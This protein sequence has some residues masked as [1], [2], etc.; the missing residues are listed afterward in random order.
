MTS[1]RAAGRL[2]IQAPRRDGPVEADI[3]RVVEIWQ[4]C[5]A[6][7]G[8]GGPFLFGDYSAADVF[9]TPVAA[10]FAAYDVDLPEVAAAYRDAALAWPDVEEWRQAAVAEPWVIRFPIRR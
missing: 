5:R 4:D 2:R 6:R 9:Y 1:S 3:A 8:S 7:F 10:R